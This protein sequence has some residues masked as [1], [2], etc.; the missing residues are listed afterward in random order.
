MEQKRLNYL[1]QI[2]PIEF[3]HK[4]INVFCPLPFFFKVN[5]F[6]SALGGGENF[7]NILTKIFIIWLKWEKQLHL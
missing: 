4:S 7:G 2:P 3:F 5:E 1:E 6:G